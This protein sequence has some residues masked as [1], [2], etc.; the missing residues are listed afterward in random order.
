MRDL[1]FTV[2]S[3]QQERARQTLLCGVE[4]LVDR[5]SSMRMFR[6][7]IWLRNRSAKSGRARSCCTI[8]GLSTVKTV[9]ASMAV[10][11]AIRCVCPAKQPSPKKWPGSN[12]ATTASF[13]EWEKD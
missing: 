7:S 4:E 9:Q 12:T 8:S 5:S 13:P 11:V 2:S 6:V 1:W 3:Q 10:A